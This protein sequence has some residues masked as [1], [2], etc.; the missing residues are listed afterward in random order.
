MEI[1]NSVLL[2]IP[3]YKFLVGSYGYL[4]IQR[5]GISIIHLK[6][7]VLFSLPEIQH[8]LKCGIFFGMIIVL[9]Y[10]KVPMIGIIYGFITL[11]CFFPFSRNPKTGYYIGGSAIILYNS[12]DR[13]L[14]SFLFLLGYAKAAYVTHSNKLF[15]F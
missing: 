13:P 8:I 7:S 14:K 6:I 12:F 10:L 4:L 1:K 9:L 11:C 5:T 3:Y 2:L 15:Q